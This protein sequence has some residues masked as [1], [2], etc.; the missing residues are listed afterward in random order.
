MRSV[1]LKVP[2]QSE[3]KTKVIRQQYLPFTV[4]ETLCI[5]VQGNQT[6]RSCNSAYRSRYASKGRDSRGAKRR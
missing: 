4:L 5:E 3:G 1:H 6:R 2:E